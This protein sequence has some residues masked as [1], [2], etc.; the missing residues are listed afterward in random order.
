M[1]I[2]GSFEADLNY[3]LDCVEANARKFPVPSHMISLVAR[4]RTDD[5]SGKIA[6]ALTKRLVIDMP[7]ARAAVDEAM[8][9]DW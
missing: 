7:T 8:K 6:Y 9:S 1:K 5:L 3:L 4:L 2:R